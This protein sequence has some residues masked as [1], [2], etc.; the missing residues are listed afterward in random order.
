MTPKAKK[1]EVIPMAVSLL[2]VRFPDNGNDD[3]AI[4]PRMIAPIKKS[5]PRMKRGLRRAKLR[6]R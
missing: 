6:E 4:K 5:I 3:E 2:M 1:D